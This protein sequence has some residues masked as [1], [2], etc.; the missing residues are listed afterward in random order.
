VVIG[1]AVMAGLLAC[2]ITTTRY[3]DRTPTPA[4]VRS[5]AAA[6]PR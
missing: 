1:L 2:T 6:T 4:A 3:R 5:S